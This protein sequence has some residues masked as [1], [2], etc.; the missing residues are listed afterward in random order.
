MESL[1]VNW[2]KANDFFSSERELATNLPGQILRRC[3]LALNTDTQRSFAIQF[4]L[5]YTYLYGQYA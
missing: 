5:F 1:N 4:L 3:K 2:I